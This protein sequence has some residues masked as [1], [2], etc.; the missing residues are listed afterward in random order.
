MPVTKSF[1]ASWATKLRA[2]PISPAEASRAD[3]FTPYQLTPIIRAMTQMM[4]APVTSATRPR[5]ARRWNVR[6][7]RSAADRCSG[8]GGKK[9]RSAM[10]HARASTAAGRQTARARVKGLSDP[11]RS[12]MLNGRVWGN[13]LIMRTATASQIKTYAGQPSGCPMRA[14][15]TFSPTLN[16][17]PMPS[18]T[19]AYLKA[20]RK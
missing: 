19:A 7:V 15:P 3:K 20:Q 9:W 5:V 8:I 2:T 10:D 16:T 14:V 17:S 1:I 13:R 4:V 6:S 12:R 18:T 11:V